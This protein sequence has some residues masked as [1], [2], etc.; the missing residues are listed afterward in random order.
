MADINTV[1]GNAYNNFTAEQ[2]EKFQELVE[3]MD[4][5][6]S[7]SGT[8]GTGTAYTNLSA[9]QSGLL[10]AAGITADQWNGLNA[11]Q[12]GL[13]MTSLDAIMTP[14]TVGAGAPSSGVA[15]NPTIL[16]DQEALHE[17]QVQQQNLENAEL[18]ALSASNSSD[19]IMTDPNATFEYTDPETGEV[20]QMSVK[21]FMEQQGLDVPSTSSNGREVG[22]T[23]SQWA[24]VANTLDTAQNDNVQNVTDATLKYAKDVGD[25]LPPGS[26]QTTMDALAQLNEMVIQQ[27]NAEACK[28]AVDAQEGQGLMNMDTTTFTYTD[29]TT[30]ETSQMSVKDYCDQENIPYSNEDGDD[31]LGR[32]EQQQLQDSL[33]TEISTN[34]TQIQAQT[35]IVINDSTLDQ[36]NSG[37][38]GGDT[39]GIPSSSDCKAAGINDIMTMDLGSLMYMVLNTRAS[40]LDNQVR[41]YAA[42]VQRENV[43]LQNYNAAMEV[44][45][46]NTN[47]TSATSG[48][49]TFKYTDPVTGEVSDMSVS[50]FMDQE[51]IAYPND[52][53]DNKYS[54]DE[55]NTIVTNIKGGTSSLTSQSQLDTTDM[56][57]EIDKYQQTTD[58]ITNFESKWHSMLTSIIGNL[59]R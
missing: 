58:M 56:Q 39:P 12:Q 27:Q 17:A 37:G 43:E 57:Q 6:S 33:N 52:D 25:N 4:E 31:T 53:G 38:G 21:D 35:Q 7:S 49:Q 5:S 34:N 23:P 48:T 16:S 36:V 22:W 51:G 18:V 14:P 55:W 1:Y 46:S 47:V 19:K 3:Q 42:T 24:T 13:I 26:S 8:A 32:G 11:A 28:A 44:A 30:G 9:T 54:A 41:Q 15:T 10:Q 20:S 40:A 2:K 59:S 29:P 50:D 45:E